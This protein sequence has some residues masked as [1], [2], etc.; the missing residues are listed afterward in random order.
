ML[1][2]DPDPIIYVFLPLEL[3]KIA[4]PFLLPSSEVSIFSHKRTKIENEQREGRAHGCDDPLK[5]WAHVGGGGDRKWGARGLTLKEI[6]F[7]VAN[8]QPYL[9]Q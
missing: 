3:I 5:A 9:V 1:V 6:D 7:A 2:H 4:P 8:A